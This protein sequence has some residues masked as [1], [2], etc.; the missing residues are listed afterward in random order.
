MQ[1]AVG[2]F[3][4]SVVAAAA[5]AQSSAH[6]H[7]V[8]MKCERFGSLEEASFSYYS[9]NEMKLAGAAAAQSSAHEYLVDV[10]REKFRSLEE[11]SF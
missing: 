1:L 8:D 6:K 11:A 2:D 9:V 7:L 4:T 3:G 5:A 10:E